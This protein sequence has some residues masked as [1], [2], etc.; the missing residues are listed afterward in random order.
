LVTNH[1]FQNRFSH[2][3]Q[4]TPTKLADH[5]D[6]TGK[7]PSPRSASRDWSTSFDRLAER[8]ILQ[9]W[10]KQVKRYKPVCFMGLLQPDTRRLCPIS[11]SG[12]AH[13]S[14][15]LGTDATFHQVP[16]HKNAVKPHLIAGHN[17]HR[18]A[19]WLTGS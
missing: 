18:L 6:A 19:V 15:T 7:L 10:I 5:I 16:G 3:C 9:L 12:M 2:S 4:F 14:D 11:P 17:L 13:P 8:E 1:T